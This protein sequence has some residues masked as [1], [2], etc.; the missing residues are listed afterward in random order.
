MQ[1]SKINSMPNGKLALVIHDCE[2][3]IKAILMRNPNIFWRTVLVGTV[4][5][6][7]IPLHGPE[8]HATRAHFPFSLDNLVL[9]VVCLSV[10]LPSCLPVF[11]FCTSENCAILGININWINPLIQLIFFFFLFFFFVCLFVCL[12]FCFFPHK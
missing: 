5:E 8:M 3:E 7:Q 10:C 11:F 9:N 12:S 1:V 4:I 6:V 2:H